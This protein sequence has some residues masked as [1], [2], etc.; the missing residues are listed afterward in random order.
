MLTL[1]DGIEQFLAEKSLWHALAQWLQ[2]AAPGR[3]RF[4]N[5]DVTYIL[6]RDIARLD[7]LLSAKV[8]AILH[9]PRFQKLE[10]SWHGLRY[11]IDQVE[12]GENIRIRVLTVSWK[13]LVRD[14]ERAIEFDQSQ[15]FRKIY[16]EEF[17]M[18]GGEPYGVLLGDFEIRH[19]SS[20]DHPTDDV[21]TLRA[22]S[23]VSAAAFAPFVTGVHPSLLGM[24]SFSEL[25]LPLDLPRTFE[26]LE[27][28]KWKA[29]RDSEDSRF[30]GLTLPQVLMRLPYENDGTRSDGFGFREDV[31]DLGLGKYLWGNAIYAFGAVLV[32]AFMES[33]WLATIRGVQRDKR[34]GGLVTGLPVH[35]FST[36]KSGVAL[37]CS[38]NGI[39]TDSR[40][41]ELG[42][43]GFIPLC[44]C[45]DTEFSAFYGNQSVHRPKQYDEL[46][47]TVNA[48]LSSMLQY[49]LCVSRFAHYIKVMV[50]DRVGL[51]VGAADCE[52]YL[53]RWLMSYTTA[54]D[55]GGSELRAKF[56]LRE[57]RVQLRERP[58][59]PGT[60]ACVIHL[61]PHLELDQ[62]VTAVRLV[63]E[64]AP[65]QLA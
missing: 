62:M 44:H 17:G 57:A 11:L 15:L 55:K 2:C 8:N 12:E 14:L 13:E 18:A 42:E 61:R 34:Y 25:E 5:R 3:V 38:T 56:P 59:K 46:V 30:V 26:Q 24:D 49:I 40:E 29:F 43:L 19:R 6:S 50:R 10:A 4:T 51:F 27:Y 21:E 32:R 23:Q 54:S 7:S 20:P 9:D 45:A 63:T 37:K 60:Y 58:D 33:G 52:E 64:L 48:R 35:S 41:K 65:G 36:D 53:R 1:H 16:T 28:L 22:I 47:A 39:V 31:E